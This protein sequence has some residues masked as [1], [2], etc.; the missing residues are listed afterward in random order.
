MAVSNQDAVSERYFTYAN[1]GRN[2]WWLYLATIAVGLSGGTFAAT[3]ISILLALFKL[4]PADIALQISRPSDPLLFFGAI[5]VMFACF[6]FGIAGA[7]ALIQKKRP[8]D[9]IGCWRWSLF[10]W[11]LT[12]WLIVQSVLAAIDFAIVPS[13]F[14]RGGDLAPSLLIWVFSAIL[15]QTFTE[16]FIFRGYLT[17]GIFLALRRPIPSACLSGLV[18]GVVHIP[19]GWPQAINALWFGIVCAY[20]AI[21]TGGIA[22]TCGLHLANNYFGAIGV[23]SAGDVFKGLPGF[24]VQNTPQ[25]EWWDLALAILAMTMAPWAFRKLELL[26]DSARG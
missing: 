4:L 10:V 14:H 11:G 24:L 26:S 23:V 1:R 17:Q 8:K 19:N 21:R 12:A 2:Q 13:G 5:A 15:I 18:F 16:E 3:L 20:L 6:L 25:L 9:I 7:A 22:L